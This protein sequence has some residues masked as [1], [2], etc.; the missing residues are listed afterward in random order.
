MLKDN[1]SILLGLLA[2]E[3][4]ILKQRYESN[5]RRIE[6]FVEEGINPSVVGLSNQKQE[7]LLAYLKRLKA[8]RF[9][10]NLLDDD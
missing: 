8:I 3:E 9:Q 2:Q 6:W 1:K 10:I 7:E 5:I 4:H